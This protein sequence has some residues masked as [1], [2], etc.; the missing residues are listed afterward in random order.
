MPDAAERAER[1][2]SVLH[3]L[4]LVFN[5]GY[6]TSSGPELQRAD[7]SNEAIRLVREVH[8]LLP[9]QRRRGRTARADAPDRRP[10]RGA[11]RARAVN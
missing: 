1:L 9:G 7:L 2:G 4:Y 6:T 3:V 5:E 11:H 10:P 8:K